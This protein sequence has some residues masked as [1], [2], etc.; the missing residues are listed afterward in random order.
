[1]WISHMAD[2]VGSSSHRWCIELGPQHPQSAPHHIVALEYCPLSHLLLTL[3][4]TTLTE[5]WEELSHYVERQQAPQLFKVIGSDFHASVIPYQWDFVPQP[6]DLPVSAKS[7]RSWLQPFKA[8]Q[9]SITFIGRATGISISK[10]M[11]GGGRHASLRLMVSL[12][13]N[14]LIFSLCLF[15]IIS[16]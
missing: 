5:W 11:F 15:S 2:W 8:S 6:V 7:M 3:I 4:T 16:I 14:V 12:K 10:I 13:A 1:M 9:F